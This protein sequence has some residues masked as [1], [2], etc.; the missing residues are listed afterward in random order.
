[1]RKAIFILFIVISGIIPAKSQI[2]ISVDPTKEIKEISP[3]IYGRNN[4]LSDNPSRPTSSASWKLYK[5]AGV[6]FL[7]ESGGNNSTKYNWRKKLSSHPDWYNNVYA[8]NWDYAAQS[9]QNNMPEA[10]GMWAFQLL[11]YAA[12]TNAFNFDEWAYNQAQWWEGVTN[13]WCG[14]GGPGIG[15]GDPNTYLEP[16]TSDSTVAILTHWFDNLGLNKEQFQYW[17]MDNEPECWNGTHNDIMPQAIPAEDYI[18]RH[19][20]VATKARE[21][22]PEIK[23]VGPVFTNEWFWYNWQNGTVP[24]LQN[25]NKKYS[26]VEYFIKRIAEEQQRTGLRLL[27]VLD[28]HFYPAVNQ[29]ISRNVT[30]QIHRVFYDTTYDYPGANGSKVINGSWD[31]NIT[32]EYIFKRSNDWLDLYMG[33]DHGVTM[34]MSEMGS[35]YDEPNVIAVSYASL[36][37]T[38]A[39]N[40]V[41]IFTPWDWYKGQWEVLHL[42]TRY[43]GNIAVNSTS[44]LNNTVSAYSSLNTDKDML[45]VVLVNRDINN[46]QS[47]EVSLQN[48]TSTMRGVSFHRLSNLPANRETF[49]SK[50]NNA[51]QT[52]YVD[53]N[54][55]NNFSMTLPKLSV[56]VVQIPLGDYLSVN[57]DLSDNVIFNLF[58]NPATLQTKLVT[59][60]LMYDAT[61]TVSD[62]L[63]RTLKTIQANGGKTETTIDVSAFEK[64][65]YLVKLYNGNGSYGQKLI[66][67]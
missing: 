63:G 5:D 30:L 31:N 4:S 65:V 9:L 19:V 14:G 56:T 52:G 47:V 22:F 49:V 50:E 2:Q 24:D 39:E 34:G 57:Q 3:Y 45:S 27:D 28:F 16:W 62:M 26:W 17:N 10:K 25:P 37:G 43:T 29:N 48:A 13:N 58:P 64:G 33:A 41:E 1:M 18:Q 59:R 20:A 55:G 35:L 67:E 53:I 60:G 11:G 42:F 15:N 8:H 61:I 23:I 38:F 40:N 21:L 66:V 44:S 36:L 46:E 54:N 51:L 7:R 32:K 12:K 6:K